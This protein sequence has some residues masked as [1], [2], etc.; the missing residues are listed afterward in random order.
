M[1]ESSQHQLDRVRPPRV[2]VTYDVEIGGAMEQKEIPFVVGVLGDFIGKADANRR[3]ADRKFVEVTP[4]NFDAVL[5]GM[6]PRVTFSVV[7]RLS[8]DPKT[9]MADP[10]PAKV[11]SDAPQLKVDLTFG[12]LSDFDPDQIARRVEPLRKLVELREQLSNLRASLQGNDGLDQLLQQAIQDTEKAR[13]LAQELDST[14][15]GEK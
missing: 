9:D 15:G 14:S 10:D 1:S 6:R 7:N 11:P 13:R 4:D 3:L 8:E 12:K 2:H 5:E